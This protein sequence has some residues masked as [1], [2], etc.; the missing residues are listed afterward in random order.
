[1]DSDL[2]HD[3]AVLRAMLS[4][5]RSEDVDLVVASR[6]AEGGSVGQLSRHRAHAS[7]FATLLAHRLTGVELSDPM[8]GFF[9]I[10]RDAFLRSLPRL[11]SIG[12]KI[13]L[14]VAASAPT[15]L[16]VAE[17]PFVF[18]TRRH[19]ESK[20]DTNVLWEYLQLLLDKLFGR[21]IPVRFVSFALVGGLGVLVH[22]AV[23]AFAFKGVGLAFAA[24]QTIATFVA[25]SNNFFLNNVLT[26]R[27]QRLKGRGLLIGWL[28]FNLVCATGAAANVGVADWL[29]E[30]HAYWVWSAIAGVLVSVVWNYAMSSLFTWR[31][32]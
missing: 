13:L 18:G 26:Y 7:S 10:Q 17:V 28:S 29:F 27:D 25:I 5:L 30:R 9:M 21:F 32:R 14:D 19:G 12:F 4:K 22:F 20:L 15:P 11:S 16:K 23:L 3:P 6:Y 2:Q 24:A 8:S 1:M 31:N